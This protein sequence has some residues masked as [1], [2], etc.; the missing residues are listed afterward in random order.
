MLK[1]IGLPMMALAGILAFGAPRAAQARVH[2]GVA[3]GGPVYTAPVAPYPYGYGYAPYVDPYYAPAYVAPAPYVDPYF[4]VGIGIGGGY[5]GGYGHGYHGYG[6]HG[7]G[8]AFRGGGHDG[9]R[10]GHGGG[11]RH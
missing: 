4:G 10:G 3:I 11:H 8:Q 7:Y 2:F 9:F 5:Y 6:G 1:K